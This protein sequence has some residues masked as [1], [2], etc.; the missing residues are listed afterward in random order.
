VR[1][2]LDSDVLLDVL[3]ER[4]PHFADSAAVLDH[5][6]RRPGH[7]GVAWHSLANV[8][9][10][11]DG[12]AEE[13]IGELLDFVEVPATGSAQLRQALELGFADLEDAMVASAAILFGAQIIVTRNTRDYRKSPVRAVTPREAVKLLDLAKS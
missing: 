2:F 8:H 12:G 9:Y 5:A 10:L 7:A 13:F 4:L 1:L 11:M 6:V 3:L